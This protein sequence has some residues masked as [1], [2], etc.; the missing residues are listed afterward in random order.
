MFSKAEMTYLPWFLLAADAFDQV[1]TKA[2]LCYCILGD[3]FYFL[4]LK[5]LFVHLNFY[6]FQLLV[7]INLRS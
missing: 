4:I 7:K 5:S 2:V 3:S 1:F 6:V